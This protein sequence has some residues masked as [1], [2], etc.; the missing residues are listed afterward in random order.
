M[1][2]EEFIEEKA[3]L[4]KMNEHFVAQDKNIRTEFAKAFNWYKEKKRFDYDD[5]DKEFYLPSWQE[6]FVEIGKLLAKKK[7]ISDFHIANRLS[8]I[9]TRMFQLEKLSTKSPKEK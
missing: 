4:E 1:T 2:K 9:D 7:E 6:I 8:D 3:K 5:D